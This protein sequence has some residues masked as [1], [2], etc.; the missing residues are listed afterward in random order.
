MEPTWKRIGLLEPPEDNSGQ[1]V[2]M[3][4][5]D[6]II[7]HH[8]I[9]HLKGRVK[10]VRVHKD[11]T[12]TCNDIFQEPFV[13]EVDDYLNHGLMV[14]N[15]LAHKPLEDS[16]A[17]VHKGLSPSANFVF[18]PASNPERIKVG[19]IWILKQNWNLKIV[20]NLFVPQEYG[21]MSPASEDPYV[22][23]LQPAIDAGLLVIAA[24]GNSKV[25]NNLHPNRFFVVSGYNDKGSNDPKNYE[26]HPAAACG[27]NAEGYWRPDI[28]SPYTYLPLPSLTGTGF[29]YFGGTCGSAALVAGL[30]ASL[31]SAIPDITSNT[32]RNVLI[33]TGC[34]IDGFPA[35]ILHAE[36]A[37]NALQNG[38]RNNTSPSSNPLVK[39]TNENLS[40]LSKDPL[41]R[42]LALTILLKNDQMKREEVWKYTDDISPMVKK[43]AIQGLGD[44]ISDLERKHYWNKV[45][46]EKSD[47]GVKE[48]WLYTLLRTSSAQEVDKWMSLVEFITIDS[49]ICI[50]LF[51]QK[52]YP[53][54]PRMVIS[55]DPSMLVSTFSPVLEW[56]QFHIKSL[57]NGLI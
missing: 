27:L 7:P 41:E 40:I 48:S 4:I 13:S 46:K 9:S 52:H 51:L 29:D 3:V 17:N 14:L 43:V 53:E 49:L 5:L 57:R 31:F 11:L 39:V 1:E 23:A 24:G 6:D 8:T 45:Y 18:L 22:Q 2:C 10:K 47:F 55:P 15:L 19:L 54:A 56:Y 20:L 42:S 37:R 25:H 38:Y 32:L 16:Q 30:C 33:E 12:V 36:K 50:N 35:P 44:P 28:L 34:E 21:W 26:Q